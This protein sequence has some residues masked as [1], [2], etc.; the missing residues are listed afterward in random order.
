MDKTF[1]S[2]CGLTCCDCLFHKKEIY[3]TASKL[4]ALIKESQLDIFLGL[5]SKNETW[6]AIAEHKCDDASEM[7]ELFKPFQKMPEFLDVLDGI[8]KIQCKRTCQEERGCS[9]GGVTRECLVLKC[10]KSKGY[11]GCWNCSEIKN[12]DKLIF[13]KRAYGETIEGNLAIIKEKGVDAVASRGNR[14]YAWQRK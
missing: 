10:I 13:L 14:Y 2:P 5:I 12:C 1:V 7:G 6:K 3:E 8:V 4:K 11:D 9:I